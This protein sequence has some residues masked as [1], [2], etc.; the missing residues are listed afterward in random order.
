MGDFSTMIDIRDYISR[1]R[2]IGIPASD[3][4]P[5]H[6][7][8]ARSHHAFQR[9]SMR[10]S[11]HFH[12]QPSTSCVGEEDVLNP[13]VWDQGRYFVGGRIEFF[14]HFVDMGLQR[15]PGGGIRLSEERSVRGQSAMMGA[16][17]VTSRGMFNSLYF[18][19]TFH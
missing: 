17:A 16:P 15:A 13:A 5:Y 4:G 11:L 6:A 12:F 10:Y 9:D 14:A 2:A 3:L 19:L 8:V 7:L 1:E 18:V